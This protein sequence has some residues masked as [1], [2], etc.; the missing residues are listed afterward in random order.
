MYV[1]D[2]QCVTQMQACSKDT[3]AL[4]DM[5]KVQRQGPQVSLDGCARTYDDRHAAMA[6]A[7][8]SGTSTMKAIAPYFGCMTA[9]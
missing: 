3:A 5:P 7:S 2:A 4:D 6:A 8:V 9:R 1:G